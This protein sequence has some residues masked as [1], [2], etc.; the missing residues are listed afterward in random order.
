[1]AGAIN[2]L[3]SA[4]VAGKLAPGRYGDGGGLYLD[5][6]TYGKRWVF[7]YRWREP[8]AEGPGRHRE[9]G[10]GPLRDVT[11][12]QARQKA[13]QAREQL[14]ARQDP[15]KARESAPAAHVSFGDMADRYIDAMAP[16]F[17]NAKHLWQWKQTLGD[18]YC[19]SLRPIPVDRV[20]TSHVLAVLTPIWIIKAETA[21]RLRGRIERVLDAAKAQGLRSGE[22]PA[23]WRGHLNH[24]LPARKKLARGHFAAL[25][26][27]DVPALI[28]RLRS[29]RTVAA[30]CLEFVILTAARTGEAIG[31]RWEELDGDV[32]TIPA[33][34]MK[35]KR[36]HR[37]PL[38]GRALEIL[39]AM[40]E[41]GSQWVFP[42]QHRRKHLS[43][44]AMLVMLRDL[45]VPVTVHGFRSTFRDW[46]GDCTSYPKEIIETCLAHVV[47]DATE[48]AYRRGDALER[49]RELMEAWAQFCEP[50]Q[51]GNVVR[52]RG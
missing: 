30:W 44:M 9:M 36:P 46:A 25:P 21:D 16:T 27:Q 18:A 38:S 17:R 20:E 26:R 7:R 33:E 48:A 34:R 39:Q 49:R 22:N 24:L 1:M 13:A 50:E 3:T 19:A 42:G 43:N 52:L 29:R 51:T 12:A 6:D 32:W 23:R 15:I 4:K 35:A 11:L 41:H 31:M 5:V 45:D 28:A 8:G 2:K 47:G 14:R 40:R 10:L 37:V